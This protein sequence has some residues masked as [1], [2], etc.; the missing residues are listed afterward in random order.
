MPHIGQFG[1]DR[2]TKEGN[3]WVSPGGHLSASGPQDLQCSF[4]VDAQSVREEG[5]G[6]WC[7]GW[8]TGWGGRGWK[9]TGFNEVTAT[10]KWNEG[11]R[12]SLC[13]LQPLLSILPFIVNFMSSASLRR[14]PPQPRGRQAESGC[15]GW[16]GE[17]GYE[18]GMPTRVQWIS[19]T[20]CCPSQDFRKTNSCSWHPF[21]RR[22]LT[23]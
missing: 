19:S 15:P 17:K 16:S 18:E 10:C 6:M 23:L 13:E 11:R 2:L 4:C 22:Y 21:D 20:F 5:P 14:D 3:G 12:S 8:A 1:G 7:K 9:E